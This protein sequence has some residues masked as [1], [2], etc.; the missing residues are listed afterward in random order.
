MGFCKD[1]NA[2]TQGMEP[3]MPVP[4]LI[5]VYSDKSFTYEMKTPPASFLLRKAAKIE[6]GSGTP[7]RGN[8]GKVTMAQVKEV[9][10]VKLKDLNTD[11]LD[12]GARIIAGTARS[13]GLEVTE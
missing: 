7:G 11:N 6:K 8:V 3:G 13:M 1:F 10:Q 12:Q 2:R 5:T 4:C 9:A